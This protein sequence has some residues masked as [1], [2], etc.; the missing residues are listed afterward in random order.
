LSIQIWGISGERSWSAIRFLNNQRLTFSEVVSWAIE[1]G[2]K[3]GVLKRRPKKIYLCAH[4]SIA[5]LAGLA[6]REQLFRQL[7]YCKKT[8]V[9]FTKPIEV[10][11]YDRHR[12]EHTISV[13]L[14]DPWL[15]CPAG[16]KK[17]EVLGR[18]I[19]INKVDISPYR[20]EEMSRLLA[21]NPKLFTEYAIA[22]AQIAAVYT[23]QTAAFAA[24]FFG[25]NEPPPTIG[26]CAV[27]LALQTWKQENIDRH[28]VLGTLQIPIGRGRFE[29]VPLPIREDY[30]HFAKQA[31]AGGRNET[32][33]FGPSPER[34]FLDLDLSG[35]YSAAL[36]TLGLPKWRAIKFSTRAHDFTT[37]IIGF[38]FVKFQFP[39][40]TRFP[41]LPV[42]TRT[43]LIF[44][45]KGECY[46]TAPEIF[47]AR[48][49]G[50][51]L[52][53]LRGC[54]MPMDFS[55]RPFVAIS[56][57]VSE[58]RA[59]F[60]AQ[61]GAGS[62]M[63]Q[64][65]KTIGNCVFGKMAQAI[66]PKRVFS[67]RLMDMEEMKAS[68]L[69]NAYLAASVTGFIR[70]VLGEILAA[71]PQDRLVVSAT[72]D[73]FLSD[74][75]EASISAL[76]GGPLCRIFSAARQS[77]AED[78]QVLAVKHRARQVMSWRTRGLATLDCDDADEMMLARAGIRT[79]QGP[80]HE[81]NEYIVTKFIGR[82][83]GE[84]FP[85]VR[86]RNARD[87]CFDGGDFVSED[88]LVRHRM[89]YDWKRLPVS[90]GEG[91]ISEQRHLCFGTEPLQDAIEFERLR[92]RW[93]DFYDRF[94][95]PL[96]RL[97][98][99]RNFQEYL[100]IRN[101]G[102]LQLPE[103]GS[104]VYLARKMFLVAY[105][106][107]RHGL[108]CE[109]SNAEL[110]QAMCAAG[111]RT[112]VREVENAKRPETPFYSHCLEP[113]AEVQRFLAFLQE[114]FPSF[115]ARSL[116]FERSGDRQAATLTKPVASA[117]APVLAPT[118]TATPAALAV[119]GTT[120]PEGAAV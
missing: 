56:R 41:C 77:V 14:R 52:T 16:S 72:T 82:Q 32:F 84:T 11:Y 1:E 95:R 92:E 38:A 48:R 68:P 88:R 98:D 31:F 104:A 111:Y 102:K 105:T 18:Y 100:A 63:E 83:Y 103:E 3:S 21:E 57:A 25:S 45:L 35:A 67:T 10:T 85:N 9:T 54:V 118:P 81:Q 34:V 53:I 71:I 2:V 8:F 39:P 64:E 36:A 87:L 50:A 65:V 108:R 66:R 75:P 23:R 61:D 101:S 7:D 90:P 79:P 33:W 69:T 86:L 93:T 19:G 6:E 12:N 91:E 116:L 28:A 37:D 27:K 73:G 62:L 97:T 17:L 94:E 106:H 26:G 40:E 74:V 4:Y 59:R 29:I 114:Q 47:L 70:A 55:C 99:F 13:F 113:T 30:E 46:A 89:D 107:S 60:K 42:R 58:A 15:M 112:S 22:D 120:T 119:G 51:E 49:M 5:D 76:T 20:I 24:Q 44:P 96:K 43:A 109:L 78:D 117:R 80:V 110:A 115:D